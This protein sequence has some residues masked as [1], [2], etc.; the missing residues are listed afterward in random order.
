MSIKIMIIDDEYVILDGLSS[1]P[2]EAYGCELAATA[3]NG[4]EGLEL[5]EETKPDIIFTDIRMPKMDGLTFAARARECIENLR[6]V[7]LTGYD[8]FA[9]VQEAIRV[10]GSDYLLKPMDFGM[11]DKLV[12]KLC[13]EV[14]Q[15]RKTSIY[16]RDLQKTF[17][18]A[19]PYVR[20]KLISDLLHGRI[21][22]TGELRHQMDAVGIYIENYICIAITRENAHS[23]K[24][25]NNWPEQ[26]AFLNIGEEIFSECCKEVLC[27][28]DDMNLQFGFI[29]V[30]SKEIANK[31]CMEYSIA[32]A[33]K[34]KKV[35]QELLRYKI[36]IGISDVETNVSVVSKRYK[37]ACAACSQSIYLGENTIVCYRDLDNT[38]HQ[39]QEITE[40]KK[41]RL[42]MKVYSGQINELNNEL[43]M[44]FGEK[45]M[46]LMTCKYMAMDLLIACLKYPFLC[47][48]KC[49]IQD[50]AY[51]FSFL[52]D[53]IRVI[54]NAADAEEIVQYLAKGFSL[55]AAQNHKDM[56][57]RYHHIVEE[58]IH[59]VKKHYMEN[60]TLD[61]IADQFHMSK[62]YVSRLLKR[63]ANQSFLKIL[64]DTR[65]E[66]ACK[67][68]LEDK[69]KLYEI[70]E[71]VG[72]NDFSYFIQSFKKKYGVTPNGYRQTGYPIK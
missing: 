9:Y 7:F 71:K 3:R 61:S 13:M 41:Q 47:R 10:G 64:V 49:E 37:D 40:G 22:E 12:R 65:M 39:S 56:E 8:S 67:M 53:G 15:E 38:V 36:C 29:L 6:I 27:E 33:E 23:G 20:S 30:F 57:D 32:S 4:L 35:A 68:I 43:H 62:T 24:D 60:L 26:F 19:L 72:Y 66:E 63:Y 2:W 42:F 5:L 48:I 55:L 28:Y 16:Y 31:E 44:L 51:D 21:G 70:A 50:R 59:Y 17:E 14:N 25:E 58:I 54:S 1:F 69:Y 46:D 18:K 34:L 52:Q 11:L 45:N